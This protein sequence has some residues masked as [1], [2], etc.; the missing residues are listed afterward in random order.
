LLRWRP[1]FIDGAALR[2][3]LRTGILHWGRL[4]LRREYRRRHREIQR[5][6]RIRRYQQ[7][8]T[9]L[10]GRRL[11]LVDAPSFLGLYSELFEHE[12]Y[13]FETL[14]KSP[15]IIDGGANVGVSVLYFKKLY[16]EC[17]IIAFEPDP[18]IFAVLK[19]NCETFE[20]RDVELIP[21]ALWSSET[22]LTFQQEGSDGGRISQ[23]ED[24]T[25]LIS[26][27]A[28]R[29][30]DYLHTEV[31]LLKL[32]IE[33]AETEVLRDCADGLSNVRRLFVEYH[34]FEASQQ[35]LDEILSIL[36]ELDFR[37]HMHCPVSSPRPFVNRSVNLGMDFQANI[38]AFRPSP[39]R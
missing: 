37:I 12:I 39:T 4:A 11:E 27:P 22:M 33:G 30:K 20:L 32:D 29:L 19:K 7:T 2:E 23:A 25:N 17:R 38:F 34:S 1:L 31:D 24:R 8:Y 14:R 9:S 5:L 18:V 26:V 15:L 3:T 13:R 16:P 6:R 21:K 36:R 28:C 10:L 35:T